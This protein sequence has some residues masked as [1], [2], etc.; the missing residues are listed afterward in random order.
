MMHDEKDDS[1]EGEAKALMGKDASAP[2]APSA[3]GDAGHSVT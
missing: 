2:Q 1:A 3:C